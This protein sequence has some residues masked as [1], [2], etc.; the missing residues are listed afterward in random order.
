[1][2]SSFWELSGNKSQQW[3][4]HQIHQESGAGCG[5]FRNLCQFQLACNRTTCM[6]EVN[7]ATKELILNVVAETMWGKA[8]E[9]HMVCCWC[10]SDVVV[11]V[12]NK[13]M[14]RDHLMHLMHCL[15]SFEAT[16]SFRAVGSLSKLSSQWFVQKYFVF[17]PWTRPLCL[18]S[19]NHPSCYWTCWL[20]ANQTGHLGI[21]KFVPCTISVPHTADVSVITIYHKKANSISEN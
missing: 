18:T 16:C 12:L 9:G 10:D 14:S 15:S 2:V 4:W 17:R 19:P 6:D 5:A 21:N 8:W 1:M 7:I 20:T 11:A 3:P 13:C